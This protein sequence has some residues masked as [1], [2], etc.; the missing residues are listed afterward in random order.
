MILDKLSKKNEMKIKVC[1]ITDLEQL[2][3]LNSINIDFAGLIFYHSSPRSVLD[4]LKAEEVKQLKTS[5]KKVGVFVNEPV[6]Y[7]LE[8][9]EA[10]GLDLVQLHGEETSEYCSQISDHV[11]LI[12]AFRIGNT[13]NDVDW[14]V[15]EFHEACDY[16]LFDKMSTVIYGGSGS[17]F[18]WSIF[19]EAKINKPFFLGG[20][21]GPDD[22]EIIKSFNHPFLYAVDINSLFETEPGV[23]N[24][25]LIKEFVNKLSPFNEK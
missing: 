18:D 2:K 1:G 19:K 9:V 10:F 16:F 7:V 11:E 5:F 6:A 21:I 22:V 12:K 14:L 4:K 17:K 25:H 20:G 23:K 13:Q 8:Q 15:K 3:E 24:I